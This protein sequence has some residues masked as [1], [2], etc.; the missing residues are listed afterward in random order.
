MPERRQLRF[1]TLDDV[2]QDCRMLMDRGYTALGNWNLAQTCL[3]LNEWMRYSIDGYPRTWLPMRFVFWLVRL[4]MGRRMLKKILREGFKPGTPTLGAT[5]FAAD[6]QP[7][8]EAVNE[9]VATI[10]RMQAHNGAFL[11]SPLFGD[12]T[13]EEVEALE[14]RHCEHHLSFLIPAN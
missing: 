4:T 5:V 8:L 13:R 3:H 10:Q 9:L 7:D 1:Q 14:L 6:S 2:E 12:M 11:R